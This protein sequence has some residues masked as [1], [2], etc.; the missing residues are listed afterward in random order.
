MA[1]LVRGKTGL[2]KHCQEQ[3]DA[4]EMRMALTGTTIKGRERLRIE[5]DLW[6]Y[7]AGWL[8]GITLLTE[9]Q[10]DE[11]FRKFMSEDEAIERGG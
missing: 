2:I 11:G 7:I 3:A 10:Y 9:E 5:A 4:C 1:Q 8:E 6:K